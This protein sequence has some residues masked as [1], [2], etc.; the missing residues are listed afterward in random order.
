MGANDAPL[1]Q[2]QSVRKFDHHTNCSPKVERTFENCEVALPDIY[3]GWDSRTLD[4]DLKSLLGIFYKEKSLIKKKLDASE[5]VLEYSCN[6]VNYSVASSF[7]F[8]IMV[9]FLCEVFR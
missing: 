1:K 5:K 6:L 3:F 7:F 2:L 8:M 4:S 9:F